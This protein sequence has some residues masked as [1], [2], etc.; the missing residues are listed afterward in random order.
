[1]TKTIT[2]T[3]VLLALTSAGLAVAT[4]AAAVLPDAASDVAR[5]HHAADHAADHA[6]GHDAAPAKEATGTVS[7]ES[8]SDNHGGTVS[9]LATSTT[10]TGREKGAAIAAVA[11][12]GRSE[13]RGES[14]DHATDGQA[15][16]AEAS[17]KGQEAS[18]AH[19]P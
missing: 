14:A 5:E 2:R 15:K 8:H 19:R 6:T 16:A 4:A 11:S 9:E 1:M 12:D 7:A 17:A 3:S 13:A 10:L 18:A